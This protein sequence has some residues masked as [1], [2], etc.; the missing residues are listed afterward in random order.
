[1]PIDPRMTLTRAPIAP[2]VPPIRRRRGP[3]QDDR[4]GADTSSVSRRWFVV[5]ALVPLAAACGQA[6]P[7]SHTAAATSASAAASHDVLRLDD[8]GDGWVIEFANSGTLSLAESMKGDS[9]ATRKVERRSFRSG[10]HAIFAGSGGY[11]VYSVATTYATA[12]DARAVAAGWAKTAPA[13][14]ATS[15]RVTLTAASLGDQVAA[16]QMTLK[17]RGGDLPGYTVEW[18]HGD[19]IGAV[20]V[21][22]RAATLADLARLATLQDARLAGRPMSTPPTGE[23]AKPATAIIRDATAAVHAARSVHLV[24][25]TPGQDLDF[26]AGARVGA[27]TVRTPSGVMRARRVGRRIWFAGDRSFYLHAGNAAAAARAAG[28]WLPMPQSNAGYVG[29]ANLTS[30][31]FVARMMA[32]ATGVDALRKAG[33]AILNHKL[34]IV[35]Q[36]EKADGTRS[37]VFIAAHGTPYPLQVDQ[38]GTSGGVGHVLLSGWD[39]PIT[40]HAPAS[41]CTC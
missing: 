8:L 24:E 38:P 10:Y 2:T 28:R 13:S 41:A 23:Q 14:M 30:T 21:V 29:I 34:T 39:T 31:A 25:H 1:M 7:A 26:H 20:F 12:S 11:D 6:G 27:G 9:A 17:A 37:V 22:G 3:A 32:P 33:T 5:L 16:W 36:V 18:V 15:R 4:G 35:I 19:A 40:V